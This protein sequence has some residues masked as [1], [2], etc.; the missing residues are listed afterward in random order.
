MQNL[1]KLWLDYN[2]ISTI[3]S[4]AFSGIPNLEMLSLS[5]NKLERIPDLS[6]LPMLIEIHILKNPLGLIGTGYFHMLGN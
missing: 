5:R 4:G 3:E 6:L 1:T 2:Q